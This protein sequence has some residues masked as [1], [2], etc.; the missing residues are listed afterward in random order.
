MNQT[1]ELVSALIQ[2]E[3]VNDG[4]PTSGRE[5][6]NVDTIETYFSNYSSS[7]QK[8][9]HH[10]I[11]DRDSLVVRVEGSEKNAPS[12]L[13]LG[14]ID[15]VPA[16]ARDWDFDPFGGEIKDGY[17]HGRG[18][19]DMLNLTSS[20]AIAFKEI[21]EEGFKP[22]GDLIFAAV[23][24][25]ENGGALG[26][27]FLLEEHKNLVNADYVLTESGGTQ[28]S[29]N[30]ETYLP[31]VVGEKG[32]NWVEFDIKGTPTHGS[33]PYGSDNAIVSA[34]EIVK[35]F[36]D[37]K[38]PLMFTQGW[39]TFLEALGIDKSLA[40]KLSNEKKHD[41]ALKHVEQPLSA[42]LHSC[43]HN[44]FSPNTIVGGVKVNTVADQVKLGVD[45]RTLPGVSSD[46]LSKMIT[47][48]LGDLEQKV[49]ISYLQKNE[50]SIS[51][52][53]N[54]FYDL[55]ENVA[56]TF[57]PN[58]KLLPT[59]ASY[60]TDARFFRHAGAVAYGFGLFSKEIS[61]QDHLNMFHS[62]NEKV[63]IE[64]LEL[65]TEMYKRV[66]KEFLG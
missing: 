32:T 47:D 40:K 29:H 24:D 52:T 35:R 54:P 63:D 36:S 28:M 64:S 66:I 50:S 8:E 42:V 62:R 2:N 44:T 22:K 19:I 12:L 10:K 7:I 6:K 18:A 20:M 23:A 53:D 15:V 31:I 21:L 55:L 60:G 41:E 57:I 3:C 14:H 5:T 16:D 11:E 59:I 34:N 13:L 43:C 39:E 49:S 38:T 9:R 33:K 25:E 30:G 45:I 26:A 65:T 4:T 48:V 17:V 51:T 37:Y 1:A 58:S 27:E 46:D 61:F 56:N